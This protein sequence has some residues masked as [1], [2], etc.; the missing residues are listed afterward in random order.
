MTD[1]YESAKTHDRRSMA[2]L[3]CL[4][5]AKAALVIVLGASI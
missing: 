3:T 1:L 4:M 5:F 2:R